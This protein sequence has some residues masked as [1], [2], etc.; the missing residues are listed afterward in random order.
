[1]VFQNNNFNEE[2]SSLNDLENNIG[3]VFKNKDILETAITHSS[4]SNEM[5]GKVKNYERLEFLGDSLLGFITA[6]Y[7]F[8]RYKNADEGKLTRTRAALV[9][10]K[11]L[12][13][14]S[15]SFQLG[16]F[17][18]LSRGE[19]HIGGKSRPSILADIFE[20]ITAAIFLDGGIEPAKSFVLK[21][22]VPAIKNIGNSRN[23]L[24]YK[25][26]LQEI[27]Q[28]NPEEKINYNLIFESGPD[29]DKTFTTEVKIN[30]NVVGS[31]TG[32]SKKESEQMAAREAL[33]LMGF[34]KEN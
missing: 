8:G 34:I 19:K 4:Y 12:C 17:I 18:R 33:K 9:C 30:S 23:V 28:Q 11:S 25:T 20:A 29:H 2:D 24:D 10:E 26:E 3:Y 32:K 16:K 22:I 1:M 7:I 27:V 15:K 14:F 13:E 5:H 21:Y 31:G 6:E